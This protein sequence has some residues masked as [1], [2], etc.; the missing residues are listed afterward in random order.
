MSD[1]SSGIYVIDEDYNVVSCNDTILEVYPQLK[2][3]E[4]CHRCLMNLDEPCPA[5]PVARKIKGPQTYMDPIRKIY[6]TVD[7][8]DM[9]L[10]NGRPGHALVLST[11]GDRETISTLL[12]KSR[13][14]LNRLL[15]HE[16]YDSLTD[17]Y[18][19]KGFIR[20]AEHLF[21]HVDPSDYAV[22]MVDIDNF[23][24]FNDKFGHS[25]GDQC[26]RV[27]G[28]ALLTFGLANDISFYRYGG[29]EFIGMIRDETT[30]CE[31]KALTNSLM[32]EMQ[33]IRIP[34]GDP[35]NTE[36]SVT[37]SIGLAW[38]DADC[39]ELINQ[40][41]SAMYLAKKNGKNQVACAQDMTGDDQA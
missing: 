13:H 7:A 18:S 25:M 30:D 21:E 3:G 39:T 22:L 24:S 29:D 23:K 27:A 17:G 9:V 14:E 38:G 8:V 41:D 32:E 26:L 15:E 33:A 28:K 1:K 2:K 11:V 5:C 4:K 31:M 6:E 40:A 35:A 19:R 34:A 36:L 10:E 20:E 37:V 12:P 16:Y